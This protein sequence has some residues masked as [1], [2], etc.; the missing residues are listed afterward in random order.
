MSVAPLF[1]NPC[2]PALLAC[3]IL[4]HTPQTRM[5]PALR[6]KSLA[7]FHKTVE[8]HFSIHNSLGGKLRQHQG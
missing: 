8:K 4:R 1:D 3:P 5:A 2:S 6:R 7:L